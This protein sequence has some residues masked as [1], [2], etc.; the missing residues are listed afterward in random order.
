MCSEVTAI[1]TKN[2]ISLATPTDFSGIRQI[3][4]EQFP[5]ELAETK[6][7]NTVFENLIPLCTN[8]ICKKEGKIITTA[9]F[10]PIVF[11]NEYE[12]IT[13]NGQYLFGVATKE[14]FKGQGL[15]SKLIKKAS[16]EFRIKA[17]D[18]IIER[19]ANQ[20]LNN[21]YIKLGFTNSIKKQKYTFTCTD[22]IH[23][24]CTDIISQ[25]RNNFKTRFEW[26][27]KDI[28]KSLIMLGEAQRHNELQTAE[29]LTQNTY[30]AL[31]ILN[32][33]ISPK[34]FTNAFFCF[35]LE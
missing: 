30:I 16:C 22:S 10:M 32:E 27:D 4:E 19:P 3:W 1:N 17:A 5:L 18:F 11:I 21:F 26:A 8:Y 33:S 9:S 28:L 29:L 12:Q 20:N 35:T 34:S 13:L 24:T 31:N 14:E 6:Y 25:I 2:M 15:A 23:F 7:Y